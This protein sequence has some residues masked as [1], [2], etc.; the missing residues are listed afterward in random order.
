MLRIMIVD[1]EELAVKRLKRILADYHEISVIATFTNPQEAYEYA[2]GHTVDIAF[3]DISMPDINGMN[4]SGLLLNIHPAINIVFVTGFDQYAVKAFEMN[5]LDYVMKPVTSERLVS[6]MARIR[7]LHQTVE[8]EPSLEI[9]LFSGLAITLPAEGRKRM[10]KLRSP[11]T[12][13]LFAFLVCKRTASRE[14]IIETLWSEL[15]PDKAWKNL[16]ST[17]YYIR[18]AIDVNKY[19]R[20]IV[21]EGNTIRLNDDGINCD[22]YEFERMLKVIRRSPEHNAHLLER[23]EALYTGTLLKGKDYEWAIEYTRHLEMQY[24]ELLDLM[25]HYY[26][27]R[28]QLPRSLHYYNE[29]LKLDA[30][31]EDINV[32]AIRLLL[33]LGRR[34]E[35]IRHYR[36]LEET[37]QRELKTQPD[38]KIRELLR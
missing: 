36:D 9:A 18:K 29:I 13:E 37:M 17:L 7:M 35:A 38:P 4:L 15:E 20:R 25:A 21:T 34:N 32:E 1:D 33:E 22:L 19:H 14:E 31:R 28:N 3:L 2:K 24:I 5:A 12:E 23:T 10:I 6:T 16:N 8:V 26:R 11:K 27:Q 30:I